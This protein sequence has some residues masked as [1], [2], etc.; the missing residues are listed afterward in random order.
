[1]DWYFWKR[2]RNQRSPSLRLW[3]LGTEGID[4]IEYVSLNYECG[5]KW[6]RI[7]QRSCCLIWYLFYE[8]DGEAV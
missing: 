5:F 8:T 1:M 7:S 3:P 4:G 2:A 6:S